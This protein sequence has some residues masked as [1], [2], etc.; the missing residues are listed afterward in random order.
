M[1]R[2]PIFPMVRILFALLITALSASPSVA[3][4]L[5]VSPTQTGIVAAP[6]GIGTATIMV[7]SSKAERN[8]IRA[9][10][11]DFMRNDV[12]QIVA[13]AESHARSARPWLE[14]SSPEFDTPENGRVEILVTARVPSDARGSYWAMVAL[15]A[16]PTAR[17]RNAGGIAFQIVPRVI[18]PVIVTVA[19]TEQYD[20]AITA[21]EAVH[22]AGQNA[23]KSMI[24]VENRGNAAVMVTGAFTLERSGAAD[25]PPEEVALDSIEPVTSLPGTTMRI[26]GNLPWNGSTRGLQAH[27]YVR[28]GPRP[29]DAAEAAVTIDDP[30][31]ASRP[32]SPA[33]RLA[34]PEKP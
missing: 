3:R 13:V 32:A 10:I 8:R 25:A 16:L 1:A 5:L 34:A 14:V 9:T 23:V 21:L 7:A 19:G 29:E 22:P 27:A 20:V 24:T 6:G 26:E 28:Y 15:E 18:V 12:G 31:A 30:A 17:D 4:G 11:L 33:E 2:L